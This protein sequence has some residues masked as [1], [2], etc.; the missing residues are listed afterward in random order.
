MIVSAGSNAVEQLSRPVVP[1]T[2]FIDRNSGNLT[3]TTEN[4][5]SPDQ[6]SLVLILG[7]CLRT[8]RIYEGFGKRC[9]S[10]QKADTIL[11]PQS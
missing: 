11:R 7:K 5:R 9:A 6:A 1:T 4:R 8:G 10:F 3:L 2:D